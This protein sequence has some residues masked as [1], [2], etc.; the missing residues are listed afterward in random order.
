MSGPNPIP[1]IMYHSVGRTIPDWEWSFLTVP[2]RIFDDH[3]K[4]LSKAGYRS[5]SLKDLYEYV[6]GRQMLP[7]KSVVLT[8]DDGYVDNWTY[9]APLLKKYGF[10]A[11]VF[12]NPEF[13]DPRPLI[14]P[15]LEDVWNGPIA[16]EALEVRGFMSWEEL[17]KANESGVL[18]VQSHLMT[19]TW[20]P[21]SPEVIDFRH[22]GDVCYWLD[23]NAASEYKPFYLQGD[24]KTVAP[25]GAPIYKNAKSMEAI[26]Y[27]PDP[28]EADVLASYVMANGGASFFTN[29]D[30][31]DTLYKQLSLFRGRKGI[32]GR[33]ETT[34]ERRKRIVYELTESKRL[35]EERLGAKVDFMAW[36]GGGYDAEAMEMSLGIYKSV[37][38]SS[39]DR[40]GARN[41]P[42]DDPGKVKRIGAPHITHKGRVLYLGGRYLVK[43]LNEYRGSG[44]EQRQRQAMKLWYIS[45]AKMGFR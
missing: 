3:L 5:V 33:K 25:L 22:P 41:R 27:F 13:V 36:P 30:W 37:T 20:Y 12:V 21:V 19:H 4:R 24:S 16:E 29:K 34:E 10:T 42:G 18:S 14:R 45:L 1:V 40:S 32:K 26:R 2:A 6:S 39:G 44:I 7:E 9:A 38:L 8:F 31:R 43:F 23:W 28:D 15:T 17:K 35:I 11:T